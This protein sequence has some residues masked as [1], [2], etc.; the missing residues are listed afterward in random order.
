M[1]IEMLYLLYV[2]FRRNFFL[3]ELEVIQ[4]FSEK[5]P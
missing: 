2:R 4:L 5:R 1:T 3:K